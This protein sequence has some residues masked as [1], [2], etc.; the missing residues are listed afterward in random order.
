MN[1]DSL[2]SIVE[3]SNITKKEEFKSLM[4]LIKARKL[5]IGKR[6]GYNLSL[7]ARTLGIDRKTLTK[8]LSKPLVRKAMQDEL[9]FYIDKMMKTGKND[10]RQWKAQID[11]ATESREEKLLNHDNI[12]IM[13][14]SSPTEFSIATVE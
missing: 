13:I 14:V 2:D 11:L 8:W 10:W 4:G 5:A 12:N 3:S 6:T 7:I 9:E 1:A